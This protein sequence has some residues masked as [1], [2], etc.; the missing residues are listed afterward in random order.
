MGVGEAAGEAEVGELDLAVGG[1]EAVVG[2]DVAV[3]HVVLVAEPDGAGE[4]AHPGLDVGGAVADAVRVADEALEVA[5][6]E[7][8]EHEVEVLVLGGE[9]VEEGDDVGVRELL[10]VLELTHRVGRHALGVLLLH[11]DLL[12]GHVDRRPGAE[13]AEED[14]GV[15][16]LAE[17]LAYRNRTSGSASST[18]PNS[19]DMYTVARPRGF[20]M[21]TF[22]VQALNLFVGLLGE[23]KRGW[24]R[25]GDGGGG[26]A[27]GGLRCAGG[28]RRLA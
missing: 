13:L 27:G 3:E 7:E 19:G 23:I 1:D 21:F 12:D 16:S 26:R 10:E 15:R 4:H 8:L 18:Y 6:G 28:I 11:L 24:Y 9:D 22:D 20:I 17:L 14:I 5:E 2:L 25:C